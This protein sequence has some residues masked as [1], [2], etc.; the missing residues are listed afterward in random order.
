MK[1]KTAI[2]ELL[3]IDLPILGAPMFLVSYPDL[4]T[5]VSEAGG[6]GCFPSLNYRSVDALKDAVQEIQSRTKKPFGV[7]I[8]LYKEHNPD[9]KQQLDLCLSMGVKL[10][11]TSMGAPR[12]AVREAKSAG[13]L[14]FCDVVNL[15]MAEVVAKAGADAV[16]AVSQGAGGHAGN[17]SP[18]SLIPYL[19]KEIGL[20]V[21][22]AGSIGTGAQMAAAFSLGAEGVYVGTRLIASNE[23]GAVQEYK[24]MLIESGPEEIVYTDKISGVHAN[25]LSRSIEKLKD[26]S[27]PKEKDEM[28]KW[29]DLWSAGHGV[30]QIHEIKPAAEIINDMVNEYIDV[31]KNLA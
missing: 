1:I 29:K 25:W 24:K 12:T 3:G 26:P 28:K 19:K 2:T 13:S 15:R 21:L 31:K 30:A 8:V 5:A 22:G 7:N 4:V 23:S 16:I 6:L 17:I 20:P 18:F 27:H 14:V 11:I 9:W 10:I